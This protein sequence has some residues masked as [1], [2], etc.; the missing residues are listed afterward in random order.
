MDQLTIQ[1]ILKQS[2][3][4]NPT[5]I[6]DEMLDWLIKNVENYINNHETVFPLYFTSEALNGMQDMPCLQK[7]YDLYRAIQD[8]WSDTEIGE[9][10]QTLDA[11]VLKSKEEMDN[12]TV[13]LEAL[14]KRMIY[15]YDMQSLIS[16]GTRIIPIIQKL[17]GSVMINQF[18]Y[19]PISIDQSVKVRMMRKKADGTLEDAGK[20]IEEIK[21]T[22]PEGFILELE[23]MYWQDT[24]S[25]AA[26]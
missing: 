23:I 16:D 26:F 7:L 12:N 14:F 17:N 10:M 19:E 4:I 3:D 9:C 8:E 21:K 15:F 25:S 20:N 6:A 18:L 13:K 24:L 11:I 2:K 5:H 22:I 1:D